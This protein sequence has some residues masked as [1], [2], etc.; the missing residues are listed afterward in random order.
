MGSIHIYTQYKSKLY[1]EFYL[2]IYV[3]IFFLINAV[4]KHRENSTFEFRLAN[5]PS[6]TN[7]EC[8]MH[9]K[10]LKDSL[11][12]YQVENGMVTIVFISSA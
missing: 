7:C 11:I 9:L 12:Q 3:D 6:H 2:Y 4:G 1:L 10:F 8:M 5:I